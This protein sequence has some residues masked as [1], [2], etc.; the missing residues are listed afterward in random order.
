M[1]ETASDGR[2]AELEAE[3]ARLK[4]ELALCVEDQYCAD[5]APD[6]AEQKESL[7]KGMVAMAE[8]AANAEDEVERLKEQ[9]KEARAR[10]RALSEKRWVKR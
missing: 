2:I 3:I 9:L 10:I 6:C 1:S 7:R 5:C 4:E 8:R